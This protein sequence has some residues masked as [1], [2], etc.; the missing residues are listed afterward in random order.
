MLRRLVFG[1]MIA[2]LMLAPAMAAGAQAPGREVGAGGLNNPRGLAFGPDGALYVVEA[3]MGGEGPC[4]PSPEGEGE[5]CYGPTGAVTRIDLDQGAQSQVAAGLPSLAQGG[6]AAT[7]PHDITFAGSKMLVVIGLGA[8]PA[9]RADLGEVGASFGRLAVINRTG[10]WRL[11]NDIS[12]YETEANPDGGEVDSNPYAIVFHRGKRIVADAGGNDLIELKGANRG[13]TLAVFPNREAE[14]PPGS[15]AMLP[16]QAVPTSVTVGPDGAYYVGQLTGFPF[17]LGGANVYRVASRQAPEVF[18]EGFTNI[19]DLA[20]GPD[21]NLYVL[22]I[23]ANGLLSG[24]PMGALIRVEADGS[25]TVIADEGL[26]NPGGLAFG[27]DGSIYISN[28]SIFPGMGEV[29][30]IAP[31]N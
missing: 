4:L 21:G 28:Y 20:F 7:G 3:G 9:R 27:P 23:A 18:A 26:V 15:G 22:E 29:V 12:A 1:F 13:S 10:A 30:R 31:E 14:F 19:I 24:D 5:V 8:D 6:F 11:T 2:A 16:M 25:H 17:P